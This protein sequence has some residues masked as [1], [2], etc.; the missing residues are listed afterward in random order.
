MD[1]NFVDLDILLTHIREPRSRRYFLDAV[2]AYKAGALRAAISSAWVAVVY[3][4]ILKYQELSNLGN[5]QA[6]DYLNKW[7]KATT[8]Q[9]TAQLLKLE[10]G[11]LCHAMAEIQLLNPS[12][13]THL[14]RLRQDRHLCAHP[15]FDT[16]A[17]LFEPSPELVRLHLVNAINLVLSQTPLQGKAILERFSIDVQSLGFP[18]DDL[19]IRDYV[20]EQ[21]LACTRPQN[22]INFGT[23]L[24]KSLLQGV[25]VEWE[26]HKNEVVQALIAIRDGVPNSWPELFTA[27]RL[28]LNSLPPDN[29]L[30]IRS[31]SFI[32][33]FPKFWPELNPATRTAL[34]QTAENTNPDDLN[35][36]EYMFLFQIQIPELKRPILQSIDALPKKKLREF[37]NVGALPEIWS[38]ALKIY[39]ESDSFM[40]SEDNFRDFILPFADILTTERFDSLLEAIQEQNQNWQ[41]Y[42]TPRLL[43]ELMANISEGN[44]PTPDARTRFYLFLARQYPTTGHQSWINIYD[45]VFETLK[46]GGWTPPTPPDS[47]A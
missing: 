1:T 22:I 31:L 42:A 13:L 46:Q 27:I 39:K 14:E 32:G 5:A 45:R 18:R 3:D 24:A 36:K 7:N 19:K 26:N 9:N 4:L 30:R 17:D 47:S 15:A 28:I 20:L 38:A 25:P 12:S 44:F 21:Y 2:K 41:A 35:P 6:T 11:I 33:V 37:L 43:R 23:V 29:R 16:Q 34:Q 8:N 40:E 10:T